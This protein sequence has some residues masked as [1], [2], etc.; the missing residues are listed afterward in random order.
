M[1]GFTAS[2]QHELLCTRRARIPQLLLLVFLAMVSMSSFI[3]W[4]T[5]NTVN[6]VYQQISADGLTTA[7]N[8]FSGTPD[9]F[10][11][12]NSTIYVV[13]IGA[14]MAIVLG[15]Q[16]TIRDRKATTY[17]LV[18]SRPVTSAGRLLGQLAALSVVIA[19]VLAISIVI[20]WG[21]IGVITGSILGPDS[22][23][24]LA[25][26]GVLSWILLTAFA[27]VGMFSGIYSKKETTALLA[28][29]IA[30][31]VVAFI[32]PQ[33]GTAARPVALLN[34]IPSI[35]PPSGGI[36]DTINLFTGP[37]AIT[38]QFKR[39]ASIVLKDSTVTGSVTAATL[40]LLIF[41][42]VLIFFVAATPRTKLGSPLDD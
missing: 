6:A 28:P 18:L 21:S 27:M 11:A 1:N 16:S 20:N 19:V 34:P 9:L 2:F 29:F 23:T 7:P 32:L 15:V 26:F 25:T 5:R 36:F 31:S 14:L 40:V 22:T 33:L 35:P 38:E 4:S 30:W 37:L 17:A 13:L 10:Y 8:P 39:A 3:G 24:R 41:L 12:Q 42:V